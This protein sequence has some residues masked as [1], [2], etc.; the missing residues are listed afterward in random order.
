MFRNQSVNV[1]NFAMSPRADVPRSSFRIQKTH[2]TTFNASELVP[3]WVD[4][5][6]P[7]DSFNLSMTAFARMATPLFP[8]MDNLHFDTFFFFVPCRLVWNNWQKFMGEQTNPGDST[9]FL[10]PTVTYDSNDSTVHTMPDFF[11]LP[12]D[13]QIEVG[14]DITVNALPFRAYNLIYNEWFRDENLQDSVVV[15]LT[16]GPDTIAD[17]AIMR[18]GKRHDYLA[19]L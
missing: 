9:D 8:I 15:P 14:E 11:G 1:K 6:L 18:R 13:G 4:E 3:M 2:K 16:D 17:Y 10:I 7:G 12:G 5:V 19:I